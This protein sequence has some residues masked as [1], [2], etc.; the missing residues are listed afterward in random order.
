MPLQGM[1]GI[2]SVGWDLWGVVNGM[3]CGIG[4]VEQDQWGR[5]SGVGLVGWDLGLD[6]WA[7]WDE[8]RV[9]LVALDA[10]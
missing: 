5:I 3:G 9:R 1:G 4:S 8:L 2:G 10:H 7:G 6:Q